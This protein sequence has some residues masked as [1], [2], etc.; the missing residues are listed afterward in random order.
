MEHDYEIVGAQ[1]FLSAF[2]TFERMAMLRRTSDLTKRVAD[3]SSGMVLPKNSML[4]M[5]DN[6]GH[7]HKTTDNIELS[8]YPFLN[9]KNCVKYL[10][11]FIDFTALAKDDLMKFSHRIFRTNLAN[12]LR[13]YGMLNRKLLIPMT[14]LDTVVKNKNCV[15]VENYNPL[16]R[17]IPT[18]TRPIS[19][20]YRY[21]AIMTAALKNTLNYDRQHFIVIPVPDEFTYQRSN[22]L[23]IV[24]SGTVSS[25]KLLSDSHFYFFVLDLVALLLDNQ[26]KL[27]TLN[28]INRPQLGSLNVMLVNKTKGIV[29]NI[30]KLATLAHTKTYVF[31]F[32]NNIS[33]ISGV[34]V[35]IVE[36][37]DAEADPGTADGD[38][39]DTDQNVA[40][41]ITQPVETEI[42]SPVTIINRSSSNNGRLLP[43][44][45]ESAL[46]K[47]ADKQSTR[48]NTRPP[49][50]EAQ[51]NDEEAH[52]VDPHFD[53]K[54]GRIAEHIQPVKRESTI[55][56]V[57]P[58][59]TLSDKQ[60]ERVAALST[61]YHAIQ[62]ST[63]KGP[64]TIKEVLDEPVDIKIKPATINVSNTKAH[65]VDPTMTKST[66]AVFD[67]GYREKLLRKDILTMIVSFKKNGLFLTAYDEKNDYTSFTRIKYVKATFVDVRS[68]RHTINFKLP[69]PDDE[70]YYLINGVRLS[71][72]KQLVN[73][74]I[75]KISPTRVS[76][77]SNY[78]KTLVDKVESTRY[79]LPDLLLKNASDLGI[80][81]VPG[82]N[83]YI[84][85]EAPYDY[86]QLG[87]RFS[88][89]VTPT[90]EFYFEYNKRHEHFVPKLEARGRTMSSLE[91]EYGVLVGKVNKSATDYMFIDQKNRCVTLN[92]ETGNIVDDGKYLVNYFGNISVPAEW[93]NHKTLDKNLPIIFILAYR[94][95]LSS[96]LHNLKIKHRVVKP[97]EGLDLKPT[98]IMVQFAD[99]R[100]VFD[101][102]PLV[103]SYILAG[104][105]AFTSLKRY[106]MSEFD[107][108]DVYYKLLTDKGMST[109]YLRGIDNYFT[110]FVDP[111]TEEVLRE[112]HEPTNSRDLLI[113]AVEMLTDSVDKAPSAI[114]NFRLRSAEKIPAMIYNEISRQY[115]NY[116]NSN[117]RDVSFSINTEA[118]FQ[119]LIKD[120]TMMAREDT[121]PIHA[122]KD[123]NKVTYT[124][125]GGRSSDAF[126]ARDRKYPNDAPGI[127]AETTT[128]GPSVGMT[129]SLTGNPNIKNLRGMFHT[130]ETDK[131]PTNLLNDTTLLFTCATHDAPKRLI[132]VA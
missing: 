15:I 71:M 129:A 13:S 50:Q 52:E 43:G 92:L 76:L 49:T 78:N 29:F 111:I 54:L 90:H 86:K 61:R 44:I 107:G 53:K 37:P 87:A 66:T 105:T 20:Y 36:L 127:I 103:H 123:K 126:V 39:P 96:V 101:R 130:G 69:M 56:M 35:P 128:D 114:T 131:S 124:G 118:I 91:G 28:V 14:Q 22:M 9:A 8:D 26:S 104:F 23:S 25:P 46:R 93:C 7:S 77:I 60:R 18:N 70:G 57:E 2:Y 97:D 113:R 4:H 74:P 100:L 80:K 58:E 132:R 75:C 45:L 10:H 68:K 82:N 19:Q 94:Y 119:R 89:L 98:E 12:D 83:T 11:N 38:Q 41:E 34:N 33:R 125:F 65:D 16:Y 81:Y 17:V 32:A 116:I 6:V 62:V 59:E 85:I 115:A 67:R 102:Y 95:G 106:P 55:T 79:S 3:T 40:P 117:Y 30:G 72:A 1:E 5:L 112:M 31:G 51:E 21:R 48:M 121:N 27:S 64:Q 109:N 84:G 47:K 99:C 108:K 63:P 42:V 24:Q 120:E 122:I 110:F 73:I 88:K